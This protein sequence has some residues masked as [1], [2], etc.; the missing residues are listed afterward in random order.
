M[1]YFA[2]ATLLDDSRDHVPNLKQEPQDD[3]EYYPDS[4]Y[5]NI[6]PEEAEDSDLKGD[7]HDM[8]KVEMKPQVG[9]GGSSTKKKKQRDGDGTTKTKV[10]KKATEAG[11]QKGLKAW[12]TH[13]LRT[14]LFLT[15]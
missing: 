4:D 14:K 6:N 3:C 5:G 12:K 2:I 10:R 9:N 1:L 15:Y 8:V 7:P 11:T 13:K